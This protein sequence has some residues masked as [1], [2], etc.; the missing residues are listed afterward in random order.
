MFRRFLSH[1]VMVRLYCDIT[2]KLDHTQIIKGVQNAEKFILGSGVSSMD[3][4]GFP[5]GYNYWFLILGYNSSK[6]VITCISMYV[7]YYIKLWER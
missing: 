2:S 4:N 3:L 1:I 7:E 6:L 5:G